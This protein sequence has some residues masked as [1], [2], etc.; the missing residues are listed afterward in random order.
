MSPCKVCGS[1]KPIAIL[2]DPDVYWYPVPVFMTH[3]ATLPV[4]RLIN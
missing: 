3:Y 4:F 1:I 2:F